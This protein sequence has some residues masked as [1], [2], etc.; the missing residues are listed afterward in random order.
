[1]NVR[2]WTIL[3][4]KTIFTDR[5]ILANRPD[6]IVHNKE[7]KSCLIIDI[8][9]PDDPNIIQKEAEKMNKCKDLQIE[10]QRMWNTSANVVPIVILYTI[11]IGPLG[12]VSKNYAR[13]LENIPGQPSPQHCQKIAPLGTAGILRKKT[14]LN[15]LDSWQGSRSNQC[16]FW[17]LW[18]WRNNVH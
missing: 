16:Q 17:K 15:Q 13:N 11:V 7:E 18:Q 14:W 12:T 2:K 5:E 9:V 10:I 3:W 6:I 8:S 1:M 4:D